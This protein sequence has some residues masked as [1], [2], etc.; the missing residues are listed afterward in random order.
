M[1]AG[2]SLVSTTKTNAAAAKLRAFTEAD[3]EYDFEEANVCD[4]SRGAEHM[5][6]KSHIS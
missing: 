4:T 6:P 5:R 3:E 2:Q 1:F